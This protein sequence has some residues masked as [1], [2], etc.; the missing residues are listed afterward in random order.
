M[1]EGGLIDVLFADGWAGPWGWVCLGVKPWV[2]IYAAAF[3]CVAV[4][5]YLVYVITV[6]G[7]PSKEWMIWV[8]FGLTIALVGGGFYM[9]REYRKRLVGEGLDS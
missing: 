2:V 8:L 4:C 7:D 6:T 1:L 9:E 3:L 5:V